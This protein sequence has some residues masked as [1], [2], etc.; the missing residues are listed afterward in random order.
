MK[1]GKLFFALSLF[2]FI[3]LIGFSFYSITNGLSDEDFH[4]AG[5][6]HANKFESDVTILGEEKDLVDFVI[7][8]LFYAFAA[9]LPA[10][11]KFVAAG[12]GKRGVVIAS[13]VFDAVFALVGAVVAIDIFADGIPLNALTLWAIVAV[14]LPTFSF[15]LNHFGLK[16]QRLDFF[17]SALD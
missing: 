16:R 8:L 7:F 9:C 14:A 11:I 4:S 12:F 3:A 2:C 6:L 1:Y 13:M 10:F 17:N 5:S 15:I